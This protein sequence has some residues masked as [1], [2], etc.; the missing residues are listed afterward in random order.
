MPPRFRLSL[1]PAVEVLVTVALTAGA[2][3]L[4]VHYNVASLLDALSTRAHLGFDSADLGPGFFVLSCGLGLMTLRRWK[5]AT[6]ERRTLAHTRDILQESEDRYRSLVEMSPAPMVVS[7]P[8][9]RIVFVNDAALHLL[10]PGSS[11]TRSSA[12][13]RP[14]R[15]WG[16]R[17]FCPSSS[18]GRSRISCDSTTSVSTD[19]AIR[20]G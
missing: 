14:T 9:G 20:S 7:D 4:A 8:R 1:I 6:H 17:S 12:S 13:S 19:R 2:F 3:F 15:N 18:R 5:E 10:R 11:P 16:T